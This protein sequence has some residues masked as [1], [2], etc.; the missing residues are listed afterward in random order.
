MHRDY[1]KA[2]AS[3]VRTR[4][5]VRQF[6]VEKEVAAIPGAFTDPTATT[7]WTV[8]V[9]SQYQ[10]NIPGLGGGDTTEVVCSSF[11]SEEDA[12]AKARAIRSPK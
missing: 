9:R 6:I 8:L 12:L 10:V 11:I 3:I 5:R 2:R 4:H 7:L 1:A